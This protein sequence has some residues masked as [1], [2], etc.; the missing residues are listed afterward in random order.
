MNVM[1]FA[2]VCEPR[3][4]YGITCD[5]EQTT[6]V[7]AS[8]TTNTRDM[9]DRTVWHLGPN[10]FDSSALVPKC[11]DRLDPSNQRP[12]VSDVGADLSQFVFQFF[13]AVYQ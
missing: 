13:C 9:N 10:C 5:D 2:G 8:V 3:R 12:S 6:H 4:N 7:S 1:T 11:P